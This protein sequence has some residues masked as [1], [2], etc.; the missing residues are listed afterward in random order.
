MMSPE[1][2][3]AVDQIK[4]RID[5]LEVI[6]HR[7]H[8]KREGKHFK[9]LCPFH[10]ESTPSFMIYPED[11]T[12]YCFG[13]SEFGDIIMFI[14]KT[15]NR[16]FMDVLWDLANWAGVILPKKRHSTTKRGYY[17]ISARNK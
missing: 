1:M 6:S 12:Y 3:A 14:M 8:L 15:E 16:A 17:D 10:P 2:R 13:C 7:I 9:G 5:I 11:G 4:A